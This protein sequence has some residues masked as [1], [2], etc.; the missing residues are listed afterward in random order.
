MA[1]GKI[2]EKALQGL[3]REA[4]QRKA[5]AWL[6]DTDTRGF[7]AKASPTG[8]MCFVFQVSEGGRGGKTKRITL[9]ESTLDKAR[10]EAESKRVDANKGCLTSPK[11]E[12][13]AKQREQLQQKTISEAVSLYLSEHK[14]PGSYWF[15]VEQ[16]FEN[17]ILPYLRATLKLNPEGRRITEVTKE[18]V[19]DL[20]KSFNDRPGSKRY[21]YRVLF[22]WFKWL[23][24]EG[25]IHA[26]PIATIPAP[27]V[28]D[29]RE[30]VLSDSEIKAIWLATGKLGYPWAPFYKLL[31]L[32]GQRREEVSSVEW[33]EIDLDHGLW[34]IPGRKAKNGKEHIVH[35]SPQALEIVQELQ[36]TK[37][38]YRWVFTTTS[39]THVSGYGRAK[40]RIDKLLPDDMPE[41]RIHDLR[42]TVRTGLSKLGVLPDISE[43]VLNH[44][45]KGLDA[46]Y[47]RYQYLPER[48]AA[49]EK[50]GK[51][52]SELLSERR[53]Q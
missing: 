8:H 30:R 39:K 24:S 38:N 34:V 23:L 47:N 50:W 4:Q 13:L 44:T 45:Q 18:D 6:W 52:I 25:Y 43:R 40:E 10:I 9:T 51:Y 2:T 49:L 42:R 15:A 37:G 5:I 22:P 21:I 33:K 35:L 29:S 3:R 46:V 32:T 12:R 53:E 48:K 16:K 11:Q 14:K 17:Q 41:W 36:R 28:L 20:L 19:R 1:Q 27:R 31:L 26:N 7:G